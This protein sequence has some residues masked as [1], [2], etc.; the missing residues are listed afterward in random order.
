MQQ[1]GLGH[2][3]KTQQYN[4]GMMQFSFKPLYDQLTNN[5]YQAVGSEDGTVGCHQ[6]IFSTVHGLYKER[7][8]FR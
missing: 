8:A 3:H 6:L 2:R 7:Y 1:V 4:C 5:V